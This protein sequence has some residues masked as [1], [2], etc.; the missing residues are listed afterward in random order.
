MIATL[1][2]RVGHV[3]SPAPQSYD[4]K[5]EQEREQEQKP[6][7]AMFSTTY[8]PLATHGFCILLGVTMMAYGWSDQP[9]PAAAKRFKKNTVYLW[10]NPKHMTLPDPLLPVPYVLARKLASGDICTISAAQVQL[11]PGRDNKTV[12]VMFRLSKS[13]DALTTALRQAKP[14]VALPADHPIATAACGAQ[15][16]RIEYGS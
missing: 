8:N 9:L 4:Q 5:Q 14:L 6:P 2:R 11:R 10:L 1:L 12:R 3:F 15:T 16:M 7:Q 13:A